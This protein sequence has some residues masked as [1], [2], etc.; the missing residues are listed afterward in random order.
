MVAATISGTSNSPSP[1]E[2]KAL[3]ARHTGSDLDAV[4]RE[5]PHLTKIF[6]G[7][8]DARLSGVNFFD[9]EGGQELLGSHRFHH[10]R[11]HRTSSA[12]LARST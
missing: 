12:P 9:T 11:R 8:L 2:A 10:H 7:L 1:A 3:L 6:M 4:H 5:G